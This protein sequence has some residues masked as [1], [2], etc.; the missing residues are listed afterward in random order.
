MKKI[1]AFILS[2]AVLFSARAAYTEEALQLTPY[3]TGNYINNSRIY[4]T[5]GEYKFKISGSDIEFI[6]L[7][8]VNSSIDADGF[9]VMTESFYNLGKRF[10]DTDDTSHSFEYNP[11]DEK[12]IACYINSSEVLENEKIIPAEMQ[13]YIKEHTWWL[14]ER[15]DAS[16]YSAASKLAYLSHTEYLQNADRIGTGNPYERQWFLRTPVYDYDDVNRISVISGALSDEENHPL[17]GCFSSQKIN[18]SWASSRFCF[19]LGKSFF[20]NVRLDVHSMGEAV[21]QMLLSNIDISAA[22][23]IYSGSELN[24]IG[25]AE[26]GLTFN[27]LRVKKIDGGYLVSSFADSGLQAEKTFT[28]VA[29]VYSDNTLLGANVGKYTLKAN[30]ENY[31]VKLPVYISGYSGS[32]ADSEIKLFVLD[33][34]DTLIP[35][36]GTVLCGNISDIISEGTEGLERVEID[37][38]KTLSSLQNKQDAH[39]NVS[40]AYVGDE[41]KHYTVSYTIDNWQTETC[42]DLDVESHTIDDFYIDLSELPKGIHTLEVRVKS[43]G[44]VVAEKSREIAI[45]EFHS[46]PSHDIMNKVGICA[47]IHWTHYEENYF[48]L[49]NKLGF[50]GI[51]AGAYWS[52]VELNKGILST[53]TGYL[54]ENLD[55]MAQSDADLSMLLLAYGNKNYVS[56]PQEYARPDLYPPKTNEEIDSYISF[57]KNL[58]SILKSSGGGKLDAKRMEIWNEPNIETFWGGSPDASEYSSLMNKTAFELKKQFPNV[59]ICGGAVAA[60]NNED[61]LRSLYEGGMMKYVDEYTVHPYMYPKNP[62]TGLYSN[63]LIAS[64]PENDYMYNLTSRYLLPRTENGGWV[65]VSIS[66][67]GWP[68]HKSG[69]ATDKFGEYGRYGTNEHDQSLYLV[70]TL[71]YNDALGIS[72]TDFYSL[73][74]RGTDETDAEDNFGIVRNDGSLKPAALTLSQY[75]NASSDA[76]YTGRVKLSDSVYG[77]VYQNG[78]NFQMIVWKIKENGSE[79]D[80][81]YQLPDGCTAEDMY[82]NE[83][84]GNVVSIGSEPV[85]VYNL[86]EN[87]VI[88]A[89][90]D[91]YSKVY[92]EN[93]Q[94]LSGF[95]AYTSSVRSEFEEFNS[96]HTIPE[97]SGEWLKYIDLIYET[98]KNLI[99]EYNSNAELMDKKEFMNILYEMHMTAVRMASVYAAYDES[100]AD[101]CQ[102]LADAESAISEKKGTEPESSLL[103]TD[104]IMRYAKRSSALAKEL[105]AADGFVCQNGCAA[106]YDYLA[107]KLCG[108]ALEVMKGE[109]PDISR[110]L[111][112]NSDSR[113]TVSAG[114]DFTL[115]VSADNQLNS[116]FG[117]KAYIEAADGTKGTSRDIEIKS[118]ESISPE[119]TSKAPESTGEYTYYICLENEE[120]LILKQQFK[121]IA[122]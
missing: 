93:M 114:A 65:D 73:V 66:E 26:S 86:P 78:T 80:F 84:S 68:T 44:A 122:D 37:I 112:V 87:L 98:G 90:G 120:K 59:I 70:K 24:A 1:T 79:G 110:A 46:S 102:V 103:F 115:A 69:I 50:S 21:K 11:N 2:A 53:K 39:F 4:E 38:P 109:T 62:D 61:Y 32:D 95:G 16:A 77:Y 118:G 96:L 23:R 81:S 42:M 88:D 31:T 6:L 52:G 17:W 20:E 74:D 113:V 30:E 28:L 58:P 97:N 101:S 100:Y 7:K 76:H 48:D 67:V 85:Y 43:D 111:F 89:L 99:S 91:Y 10:Y 14:E 60:Q 107:E 47:D 105:K 13:G 18:H 55:K 104:A 34:L 63:G 12:S 117:G 33:S 75:N 25:Y 94:K 119:L 121:V 8:N 45:A 82:G 83:I 116:S 51:R 27:Y 3:K 35:L 40:V 22:K 49:I 92:L 29:A 56:V 15:K 71:V 54:S 108:W 36:S 9:F 57:A 106:V 41:N 64:Y 72:H 5:P 19:Y